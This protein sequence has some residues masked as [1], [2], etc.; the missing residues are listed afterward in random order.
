MPTG[1]AVGEHTRGAGVD[2]LGKFPLDDSFLTPT[3]SAVG[4][5]TRGIHPE[6]NFKNILNFRLQCDLM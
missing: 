3:G 6:N 5:H 1:S 4:E 2:L